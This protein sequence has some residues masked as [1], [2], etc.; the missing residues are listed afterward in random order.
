MNPARPAALAVFDA[1]NARDFSD[2]DR[3][4]T[5]DFVDHGSPLPLPPGPDGYR[6]IL[7]RLVT[8]LIGIRY[9][10]VDVFDNENR[11]VLRAVG[12]GIGVDALHGAGADGRP[13]AMD[14]VHIYRTDG[15]RL[16]EHWGARDEYG[17]RLQLGTIAPPDLGALADLLGLSAAEPA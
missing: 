16:A 8:G 14:T 11:V 9:D 5:R 12:H 1:I 7:D 13:F 4:V 2:L 6:L 17:V 3:L 15:D 10:I